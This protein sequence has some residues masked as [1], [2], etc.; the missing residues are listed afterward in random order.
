MEIFALNII[1]GAVA[2]ITFLAIVALIID[3]L[4]ATK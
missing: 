2:L 4:N 3:A 1:F